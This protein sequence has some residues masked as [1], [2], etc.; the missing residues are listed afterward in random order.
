MGQTKV[1]TQ[2]H[3]APQNISGHGSRVGVRA[4]RANTLSAADAHRYAN[5][6]EGKLNNGGTTTHARSNTGGY[7]QTTQ[8]NPSP[9]KQHPL[10]SK[11]SAPSNLGQRAP[12]LDAYGV[13]I[14]AGAQATTQNR[15]ASEF[16]DKIRVCVR[17]RPLSAK[18]LKKSG[19]DIVEVKSRRSLTLHEPK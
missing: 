7:T 12:A 19:S 18:E 1:R 8:V 4:G 17:K 15:Y 6:L 10:R 16:S 13:P 11:P 3:Q 2:V 5:Q 9:A 14:K